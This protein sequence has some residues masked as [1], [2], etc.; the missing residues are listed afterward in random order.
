MRAR[1]CR[2]QVDWLSD[3]S[4]SPLLRVATRLTLIVPAQAGVSPSSF[5]SG[6][7]RLSASASGRY[8]A[9]PA[10]TCRSTIPALYQ[11]A[12]GIGTDGRAT[13]HFRLQRVHCRSGGHSPR[14]T[15]AA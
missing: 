7:F 14:A 4:L 6:R 13:H 15:V 9:E 8:H 12:G 10:N 3:S 5:A 1:V 2:G 11:V